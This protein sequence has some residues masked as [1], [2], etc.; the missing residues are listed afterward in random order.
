MAEIYRRKG[1][2]HRPRVLRSG[3]DE[4]LY[5][6]VLVKVIVGEKTLVHKFVCP[7]QRGYSDVDIEAILERAVEYIDKKFPT[8]EFKEVLLGANAY[9][10]IATG[11]RETLEIEEQHAET[12]S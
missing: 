4:K 6:Q 10:F 8:L 1:K 12:K 7:A 11:E 5:K 3:D 2:P 9:N